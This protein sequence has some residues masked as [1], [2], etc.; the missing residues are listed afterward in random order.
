M[1]IIRKN[2]TI[3]EL[4]SFNITFDHSDQ[5]IGIDNDLLRL[6][7]AELPELIEVLN[8]ILNNKNQSPVVPIN[9]LESQRT[10]FPEFEV[11]QK[12]RVIKSPFMVGGYD[13]DEWN[14]EWGVKLGGEYRVCS[15][16][17]NC[18]NVKLETKKDGAVAYHS[19]MIARICLKAVPE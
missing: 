19:I 14:D 2:L 13:V 5:T 9:H 10:C 6:D 3:Y 15:D 12:V 18:Y 11:G 4:L 1:A 8:D 17:P 16:S 7:L